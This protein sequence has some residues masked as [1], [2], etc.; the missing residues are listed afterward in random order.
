M[1]TQLGKSKTQARGCSSTSDILG[2]ASRNGKVNRKWAEHYKLL[3]FFREHFSG[4]MTS[5]TETAREEMPTWGEHMADAAAYSYDRDCALA[6]LTSA[7]TALYEIELALSRI[8]TGTYGICEASGRPIEPDRLKAIPWTRFSATAQA[9]ME[10]KGC[11]SRPHLGEL[12][13]V[14]ASASKEESEEDETE[15][16]PSKNRKKQ[17]A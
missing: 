4:E 13:T 7:Q 14:V 15:E 9:E 16:L 12:G 5:R 10:A 2:N 8:A 11:I 6:M 1:H 3:T 17:V